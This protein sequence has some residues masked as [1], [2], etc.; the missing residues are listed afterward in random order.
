[1]IIII[2]MLAGYVFA[3]CDLRRYVKMI[4]G[5]LIIVA[6]IQAVGELGRWELRR[7]IPCPDR[8]VSPMSYPQ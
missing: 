7:R 8:Q 5:L 4:M 1:M 2:A 6:V 3:Q